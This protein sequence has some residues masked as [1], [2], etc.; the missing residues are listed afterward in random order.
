MAVVL[1]QRHHPVA[2]DDAEAERGGVDG[3]EP[4]EP[5]VA[6]ESRFGSARPRGAQRPTAAGASM[7]RTAHTAT[8]TMDARYGARKPPTRRHDRERDAGREHGAA[9]VHALH[10]RRAAARPDVVAA[11]DEC[12]A[13][14]EADDRAAGE[15]QPDRADGS[16]IAF[17]AAIAAKPANAVERA[18]KRSAAR[19]A[20]ICIAMCTMNCVVTSRPMVA[21]PTPYACDRRV[22]TAPIAAM[23]QPAAMPTP[24]PPIAAPSAR[25]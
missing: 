25:A 21:S 24:T 23:F 7:S 11:R 1:E 2:D 18:P 14:P 19:P 3:G 12:E 5:R 22:A 4:V 13:R 20:G 16:A 6:E 17:P 8:T 10:E 15:R 9:A